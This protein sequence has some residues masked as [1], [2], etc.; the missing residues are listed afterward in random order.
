[1]FALVPRGLQRIDAW[2]SHARH[3]HRGAYAAL[4]LKGGYEES[5]SRGRFRPGEGAVLFHAAFDAH[6]DRFDAARATILNLPLPLTAPADIALAHTDDLGGVVRCAQ[7]DPMEAAARLMASAKAMEPACEDWP[8]ELVRA[9]WREPRL[10]LSAWSAKA[11]LSPETLSR[12]VR[13]LYGV[14]PAAL[15]G[16][17]RAHK[18]WTALQRT[19]LPLAQIAEAMGFSDQA[20]MTRAV[21][22]LTGHPPGHWRRQ[23]PSRQA[24][25][26]IA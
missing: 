26:S 13:R 19:A 23:N 18:A 7:R 1:M 2:Q 8:D 12:G 16:E 15:R 20:H 22:R 25:W 5:G 21:A 10:R 14:T 4:V 6:R 9:L 17:I 3:R 11:G 24:H